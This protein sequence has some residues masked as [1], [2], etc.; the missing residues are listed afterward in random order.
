LTNIVVYGAIAG[1]LLW[2]GTFPI[3]V[4]KSVIQAESFEKKK[5]IPAAVS[6]IFKTRG[7][8][9][10]VSGLTPCLMR[11][12]PINAATFLA[13]ESMMGLLRNKNNSL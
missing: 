12:P 6:E 11:A 4:V 2:V 10:F 7:V 3:D 5:S 8:K 13:F 1:I 9:G